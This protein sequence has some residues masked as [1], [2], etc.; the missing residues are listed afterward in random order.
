MVHPVPKTRSL[1]EVCSTSSFRCSMYW[2]SCPSFIATSWYFFQPK[3]R[4]AHWF[5][6]VVVETL[7]IAIPKARM[8]IP[9]KQ[10]GKE[11][12]SSLKNNKPHKKETNMVI[13]DH[14]D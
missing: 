6:Y 5:G 7:I 4:L 9:V 1:R 8:A 2:S 13:P 10:R 3:R 11:V 12:I 14:V